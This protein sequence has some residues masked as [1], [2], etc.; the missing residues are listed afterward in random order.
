MR[1]VANVGMRKAVSESARWRLWSEARHLEGFPNSSH[2][3]KPSRKEG[4]NPAWF[5]S[6]VQLHVKATEATN[7]V[8]K[9]AKQEQQNEV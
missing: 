4:R 1:F 8:S 2:K 5:W 3:K 9:S 7:A 6:F